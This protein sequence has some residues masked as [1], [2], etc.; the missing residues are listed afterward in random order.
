MGSILL[1]ATNL[2][3]APAGKA[4][5]MWVIPKGGK[6]E[7]A[8]MFQSATNGTAMHILHRG[9]APGATVAVTMEIETGVDSPTL[10]IV[11]GV[12]LQ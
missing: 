5:E 6:P 10:P 8:G 1:M 3:P 7:P 4:Y 2:P 12:P 9:L 11:I